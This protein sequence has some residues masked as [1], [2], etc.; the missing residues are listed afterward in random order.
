MFFLLVNLAHMD[1]AIFNSSP[2]NDFCLGWIHKVGTYLIRYCRE[3]Q[4]ECH[5]L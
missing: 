2:T 5:I 3:T 4:E 1:N